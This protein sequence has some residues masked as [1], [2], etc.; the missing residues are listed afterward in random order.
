MGDPLDFTRLDCQPD[1]IITSPYLIFFM[2]YTQKEKNRRSTNMYSMQ[3][4]NK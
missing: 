1:Q 3:A 4:N 2:I